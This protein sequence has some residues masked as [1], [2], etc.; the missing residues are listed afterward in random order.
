MASAQVVEMS[1][2]LSTTV[3]LRTP[4]TLMFIFYH[5]LLLLGSTQLLAVSLAE[6]F[7]Q[8]VIYFLNKNERFS[9]L[10]IYDISGEVKHKNFESNKFIKVKLSLSIIL[11]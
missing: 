2:I 6:M 8:Y 3:L 1:L 4:V 7:F 5:G 9:L 10:T 11:Q